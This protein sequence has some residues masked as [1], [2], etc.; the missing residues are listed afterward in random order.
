MAISISKGLAKSPVS[1]VQTKNFDK[2]PFSQRL[3]VMHY[4][5]GWSAKSA[6]N[7]FLNDKVDK[8]SSAH[9]VVGTAGDITQLVNLE[10]KA[11]HAGPSQYKGYTGINAWAIG[12]EIVN[13]GYLRK[14]ADGRFI[15]WADRPVNEELIDSLPGL[16]EAP[17]PWTGGGPRYWPLYPE[18]QIAAVED[19]TNA[20]LKAYPKIEDII[21]HRDV[22]T[23]GWKVDPGPAFP[24]RRFK[25]LLDSRSLASV[26]LGKAK[27]IAD[28]LNVRGGPGTEFEKRNFGPLARGTVVNLHRSSGIWWEVSVLDALEP[29]AN[30]LGWVHGDFIERT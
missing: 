23:R 11:W 17:D 26:S 14:L 2:S 12:I 18:V 21:G 30:Q 25:K 6:I 4:T 29:P 8:K 7:H 19:L 10:H 1:W 24:M 13:P 20:I 15:D 9:F 5:A 28:A 16:L 3:I 27:V 22:D